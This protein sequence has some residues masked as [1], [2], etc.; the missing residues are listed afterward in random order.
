M[1]AREV[2]P[3]KFFED[4][5]AQLT[6]SLVASAN[7]VAVVGFKS[8]VCYRTG[9]DV[10]TTLKGGG[11]PDEAISSFAELIKQF[12]EK[13]RIRLSTKY[14]NDYVVRIALEVAGNHHKPG[15]S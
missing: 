8:V 7:D 9:L 3:G 13:G 10:V 12:Q 4:F 5:H 2:H 11:L 15:T 1:K 6:R 14:F